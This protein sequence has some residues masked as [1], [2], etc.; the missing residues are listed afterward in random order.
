MNTEYEPDLSMKS[1]EIQ[2]CIKQPQ[3]SDLHKDI[4]DALPKE[5]IEKIKV[6]I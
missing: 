2:Q 5:V 1:N 4:K 3:I 6:I